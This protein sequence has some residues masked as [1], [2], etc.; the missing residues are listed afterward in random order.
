M[1]ASMSRPTPRLI[2]HRI[3][4]VGTHPTHFRPTHAN[5]NRQPELP[6]NQQID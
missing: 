1:A 3:D 4:P 6:L 5:L 2:R